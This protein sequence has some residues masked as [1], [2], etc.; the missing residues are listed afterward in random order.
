MHAKTRESIDFVEISYLAG[1]DEQGQSNAKRM[2][3][4]EP[5]KRFI[6]KNLEIYE[7]IINIIYTVKLPSVRR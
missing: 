3:S 1:V 5:Y 7:E 6:F 4:L 2:N